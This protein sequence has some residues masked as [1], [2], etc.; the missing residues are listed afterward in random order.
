M[1]VNKKRY[2]RNHRNVSYAKKTRARNRIARL[3]RRAN[4]KKK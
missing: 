2:G 3:S 1:N 4:R